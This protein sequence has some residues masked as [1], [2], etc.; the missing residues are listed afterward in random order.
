MSE[1]P[2]PAAVA[3]SP[4][5]SRKVSDSTE[6][7]RPP[8]GSASSNDTASGPTGTNRTRNTR[9]PDAHNDTP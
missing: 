2:A 7:T 9:A 1:W 8:T 6:A 3:S 4:A 5:A